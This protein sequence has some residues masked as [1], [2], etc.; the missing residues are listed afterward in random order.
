MN[1]LTDLETKYM[2][3]ILELDLE[4]YT[5]ATRSIKDDWIVKSSIKMKQDII[6]K[7]KEV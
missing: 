6:N 7:L 3:S 1:K 4:S 2:L 5:K